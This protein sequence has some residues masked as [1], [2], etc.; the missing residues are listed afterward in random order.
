MDQTQAA[1]YYHLGRGKHHPLVWSVVLLGDPRDTR[2]PLPYW[3][4]CFRMELDK[5][6][7]KNYQ[8]FPWLLDRQ[9]SQLLQYKRDW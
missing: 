4:V 1:G 7:W 8:K 2:R 9:A 6:R 5:L 3:F